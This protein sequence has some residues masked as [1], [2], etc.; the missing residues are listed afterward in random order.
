MAK[1][2]HLSLSIYNELC[3]IPVELQNTMQ[4]I[5]KEMKKIG[6]RVPISSSLVNGRDD[7]IY[8]IYNDITTINDELIKQYLSVHAQVVTSEDLYGMET[9]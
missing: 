5:Y 3:R 7:S 4:D 8:N 2:L 1:K 9:T 6:Y